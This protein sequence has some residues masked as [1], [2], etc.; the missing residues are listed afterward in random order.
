[1]NRYQVYLDPQVV[2]STDDLA[3]SLDISRSQIIRDV[4]SR[5]IR[6]YKKILSMRNYVSSA[7][8]PILEMIGMGKTSQKHI[9]ENVDEI[10]LRD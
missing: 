7:R 10:Y 3:R 1:M 6:E 4:V 9:S 2:E 5:V 8:N